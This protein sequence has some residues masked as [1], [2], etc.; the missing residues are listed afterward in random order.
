MP[1]KFATSPPSGKAAVIDGLKGLARSSAWSAAAAAPAAGMQVMEP[2]PIYSL[3]LDGIMSKGLDAA[4]LVGWRYLIVSGQNVTQAAELVTTQG[5]VPRLNALTTG[6]AGEM[7]DVFA[8]A[9]ALPEV[10]QSDYE[11]RTLRVPALY[12][13]ALWL[14]A[15]QGN[16]DLF[17]VV[18][19]CVFPPFDAQNVYQRDD[20]LTH[21]KAAATK[22][23]QQGNP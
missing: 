19:P 23:L 4:E 6:H 20:F 14:K 22:R 2:Y 17:L 21:L 9:E 8:K 10:A 13:T 18:P 5:G 15:L 11:I 12:V 3:R 16:A 1:L 7:E